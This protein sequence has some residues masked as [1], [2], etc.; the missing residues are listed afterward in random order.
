MSVRDIVQA[1]AGSAGGGG[2][3]PWE[4]TN[5]TFNGTP[6]NKLGFKNQIGDGNSITFKGDGTKLYIAGTISGGSLVVEY[7]LATPWDIATASYVQNFSVYAKEESPRSIFFKPDG[8]KMYVGGTSSNRVNEYSLSTAWDISS[9]S[10][11]SDFFVGFQDAAQGL[12]FKPDGTKMYTAGQ[13]N[14]DAIYEYSLS[15]AWDVTSASYVQNF[16]VA[17]QDTSPTDLFFKADGTKMYFSGN[18]NDSVYEYDL[19]TAWDIS[20]SSYVQSFS[21]ASQDGVPLGLFFKDDGT[22]VFI[23]GNLNSS[24]FSYDLSSAWDIST[25]SYSFPPTTDYFS[26]AAQEATPNGMFFKDDGTQ[27]YIIGSTGDRVY[28]YSLSVA[29]D[30]T[31]ASY[32]RNFSVSAQDTLPTSVFFKPDGTK[33]Y[34]TGA[35]GDDVNEY[36]LS[37]AWNISTASYVQNFSVAALETSP[38]TVSFK[39]D[40][41]KMYVV[42]TSGDAV[43]EYSLSTAWDISTATFIK[44][45]SVASQDANPQGMFF[46]P[47]GTKMYIGGPTSDTVNEYDLS[48]AWDVGSA[49]YV[50]SFFIG[51][52]EI[53][54]SGLSF[55]D[56]GSKLYIIGYGSDAIWSF[57]L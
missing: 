33:M 46:K 17:S 53:T 4:L 37:T 48:T 19:S 7:D 22:K 9:A 28:E 35:A 52:Q 5:A 8:T 18:V 13:A 41:T 6:W 1:A 34:I 36:D 10:F 25:A 24:V 11:S 55:K 45:F 15:T 26:V 49:S 47:D 38:R 14:A 27:M 16:S 40:G 12:F 39:T 51:S 56:D 43:R 30:V 54:I 42:G 23:L 50:Q 31:S 32:V 44:N 29:W 21:V 20:T 3:T 57:D 2:S